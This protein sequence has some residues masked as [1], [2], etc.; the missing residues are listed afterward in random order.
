MNF[1]TA[2]QETH[3]LYCG[4]RDMVGGAVDLDHFLTNKPHALARS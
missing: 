1:E 2:T 4:G 3:N